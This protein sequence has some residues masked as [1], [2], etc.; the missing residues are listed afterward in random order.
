MFKVLFVVNPRSGNREG[1]RLELV[2]SEESRKQGFEY[3]I[4]RIQSSDEEQN[5]KNEIVKSYLRSINTK[6]FGYFT[7]GVVSLSYVAF[8]V[9]HEQI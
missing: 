8:F 6:H 4:Y 7:H 1:G 3:L 9:R 5:I 2:I